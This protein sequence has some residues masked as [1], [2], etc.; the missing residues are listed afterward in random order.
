MRQETFSKLVITHL[1]NQSDLKSDMFEGMASYTEIHRPQFHF[2]AQ[3]NWINDPNGL[4]YMNGVWH[5]FFQ[6]NPEAT[7]WAT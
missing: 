1:L 6:H 7:V 3:E 5:L 2:T 4:V